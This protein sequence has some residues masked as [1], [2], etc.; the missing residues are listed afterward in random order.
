MQLLKIKI[1][2]PIINIEIGV[3]KKSEA[4]SMSNINNT[5]FV[6]LKLGLIYLL[7]K[8]TCVLSNY[9]INNLV[10]NNLKLARAY[11]PVSLHKI[12]LIGG[13][14]RIRFLIKNKLLSKFERKRWTSFFF[15][16]WEF[17]EIDAIMKLISELRYVHKTQ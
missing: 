12:H 11:V 4:K 7:R 6:N 8:A 17:A 5:V 3:R 2:K 15:S 13:N 14:I 16:V 10:R 9:Q 1:A